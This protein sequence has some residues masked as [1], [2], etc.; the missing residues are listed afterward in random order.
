MWGYLQCTKTRFHIVANDRSPHIFSSEAVFRSSTRI[1]YIIY[2]MQHLRSRT[3]VYLTTVLYDFLASEA[4]PDIVRV[5]RANPSKIY[6]IYIIYIY[7]G[8]E[9]GRII[10]FGDRFSTIYEQ[11][12]VPL[13]II[14]Y[15][16]QRNARIHKPYIIYICTPPLHH[17]KHTLPHR[18]LQ[19]QLPTHQDRKEYLQWVPVRVI[20]TARWSLVGIHRT[21]GFRDLSRIAS[22]II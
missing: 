19:R 11:Q 5:S 3:C 21:C 14:L 10:H 7:D 20:L 1:I 2:I 17:D 15:I 16:Y 18:R 9:R 4:F 8:S 13:Y 6:N 12:L 22:L